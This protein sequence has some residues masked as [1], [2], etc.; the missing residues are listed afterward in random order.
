[1]R[2]CERGTD[3]HRHIDRHTDKQTDRQKDRQRQREII[4]DALGM[5]YT[6]FY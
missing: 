6:L 3:T 2:V 1:M 5:H 4:S